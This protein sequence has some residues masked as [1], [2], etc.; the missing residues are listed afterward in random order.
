MASAMG[1][2][3]LVVPGSAIGNIHPHDQLSVVQVRFELV[4]G[5][6]AGYRSEDLSPRVLRDNSICGVLA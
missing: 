3:Y 4:A 1:A 6:I 5:I 2:A